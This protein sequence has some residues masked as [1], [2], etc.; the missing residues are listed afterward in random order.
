[1][2]EASKARARYAREGTFSRYFQGTI[3]DIGCGGDLV[4]PT[5]IGWDLPQGDAQLLEGFPNES[6]NT[7]FSS[8]CLEHMRDAR[9][10]IGRW[11]EV[12]APLGHLIVIV[13]DADLYEQG[14]WPST[15]NT[16]HKSTFSL[17]QDST[18]SPANHNL[19]DLV[20]SLPNHRLV[21]ARVID[22]NYNYGTPFRTDQ[23]LGDVEVGCEVIVQKINPYTVN[24]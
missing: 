1:M 16:D 24:G 4:H 7:V 6:I 2:N 21:S 15:F 18:W 19:I 14:V 23:S 12:V 17:H 3:L 9:A 8:H 11:W 20:R 22:T 10:A 5:A 13:P